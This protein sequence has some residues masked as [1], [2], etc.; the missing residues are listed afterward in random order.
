MRKNTR[1]HWVLYALSKHETEKGPN[2][3]P[4]ADELYEY[5][6][7]DDGIVFKNPK[8]V[9]SVLSKLRRKESLLDRR[10]RAT[11]W[12][13]RDV[14]YEYRLNTS[15]IDQIV[16]IG[17]PDQLPNRRNLNDED[18]SLS[19]SLE[20]SH[21][22][23]QAWEGS[24]ETAGWID[25]EDPE[26]KYNSRADKFER[27]EFEVAKKVSDEFPGWTVLISMGPWRSYDIEFG[28]HDAF[29]KVIYLDFYSAGPLTRG[30]E[31][32]VDDVVRDLNDWMK[33]FVE[34]EL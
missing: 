9:S 33:Y 5:A 3:A 14:N 22:P 4:N 1:K 2:K 17:A 24:S 21:N 23:R 15:G 27:G 29:N 11:D 8:E 6:G 32:T 13:G 18:R 25:T 19:V 12:D 28:I 30:W 7:G 31:F 10:T 26:V 16:E 20:Q 34:D